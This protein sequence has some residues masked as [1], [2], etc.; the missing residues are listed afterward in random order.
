M[1]KPLSRW[2]RIPFGTSSQ[3]PLMLLSGFRGMGFWVPQGDCLV[4]SFPRDCWFQ[5]TIFWYQF[6][7]LMYFL[8]PLSILVT[9]FYDSRLGGVL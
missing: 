7:V 8:L 5:H 1:V 4:F 6:D 2:L 3:I 9:F